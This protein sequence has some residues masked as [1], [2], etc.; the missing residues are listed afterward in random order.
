[1][2]KIAVIATGGK[3]Y[4]VAEGDKIFI[5]KIDGKEGSSVKFDTLLIADKD[6]EIGTPQV[7]SQVEGAII[8]QTTAPKIDVIKFKAK[9]RYKRKLGH[10][11]QKTQVEITK[12]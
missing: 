9:S 6:V 7:K 2:A 11:Q 3:Q 5:E 4:K 10:K 1:M 8:K 12:I